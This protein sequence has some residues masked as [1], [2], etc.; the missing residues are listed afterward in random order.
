MEVTCAVTAKKVIMW[1]KPGKW[2][3]AAAARMYENA[4]LPALQK[5]PMYGFMQE[6]LEILY[7]MPD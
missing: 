4:L 7:R 5:A 2:N 1:H 6:I 3:G